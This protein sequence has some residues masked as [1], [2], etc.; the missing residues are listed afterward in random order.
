M[1]TIMNS[2]GLYQIGDTL[3]FESKQYKNRLFPINSSYISD[4]QNATSSDNNKGITS[5]RQ[6]VDTYESCIVY[7][8][9]CNCYAPHQR[10]KCVVWYTLEGQYKVKARTKYQ[11]RNNGLSFWRC[12]GNNGEVGFQ[13]NYEYQAFDC[14]GRTTTNFTQVVGQYWLFGATPDFT[15]TLRA[16]SCGFF[17]DNDTPPLFNVTHIAVRSEWCHSSNVNFQCLNTI[18]D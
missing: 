8:N 13:F 12:N 16:M 7:H 15:Q 9:G 2:N 4:L 14:N 10:V 11:W 3:F 6:E 17:D 1:G 5:M 18:G